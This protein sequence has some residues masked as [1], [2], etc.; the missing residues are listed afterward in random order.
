VNRPSTRILEIESSMVTRGSLMTCNFTLVFLAGIYF[1]GQDQSL[2]TYPP[3]S[4]NT[5]LTRALRFTNQNVRS[6]RPLLL[7]WPK[8][9]MHLDY[10]KKDVYETKRKTKRKSP[11]SEPFLIRLHILS[12]IVSPLKVC[13]WLCFIVCKLDNLQ[14]LVPILVV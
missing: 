7:W 6:A 2:G 10:L 14:S 13:V 1:W 12:I 11:K 3:P 9:T 8:C 4:L 5:P